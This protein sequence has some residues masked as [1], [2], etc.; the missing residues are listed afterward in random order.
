VTQRFA[1]VARRSRGDLMGQR[2]VDM[3]E[4]DHADAAVAA[5]AGAIAGRRPFR[6]LAVPVNLGGEIRWWTL[7]GTPKQDATGAFT[8]F[9]GVGRDVTEVRRGQERIAQLARF[10]PLT[11]LANRALLREALDGAV[12][13]AQRSGR[14]CALLMVDLDRFKAVNDA[15]G[16]DAGDA[17]LRAVAGRLVSAVRGGATIARLGGDEFAIV[18][19]DAGQDRAARVAKRIVKALAEPFRLDLGVVQVGASVG[20]AEAPG[21]A[22]TAE[23]LM[24]CADLALYQVKG[25]GRGAACRFAPEIR[26]RV[27]GRRAL[28]TDLGGALERGELA[29]AFQPVVAASD[30]HV[31]GFEALLRWRHPEHGLIPPAQ[32]IPIAEENGLIVP[33]GQWVID[34]A[35]AW[36]ARWPAHIRVAVNLSPAQMEDATLVSHVAAALARNGLEPERLELEITESLFMADRPAVAATL[37]GLRGLGISFALDDF[38]TG[39]SSLGYLHKAAFSRIKIDRSF[40][41]RATN[42]DGEASHIIRA[43]VRMAGALDMATTAEGTETRAEF[44]AIR[45]LGC[46]QV[47]GYLFGKPMPPEEATALANQPGR[48]RSRPGRVRLLPV[49]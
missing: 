7:S 8:G 22:D 41:Q 48:A 46:Q 29:L 35:C 26:A 32:F 49:G 9:R 2:L 10:D 33:I 18:L 37:A 14:P 5:L 3:L 15:L 25:E 1:D 27:D 6:D 21:D 19:P 16:H 24:K 47:Q 30:E 44:E 4:T 23:A 20:H 34:T 36:A 45:K 43:I 12:A 39:Y 31:T 11:G 40:V 13:D 38:G 17:L 28:E 42:E